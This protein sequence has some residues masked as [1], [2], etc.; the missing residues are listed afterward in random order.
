MA[1]RR[2]REAADKCGN[3]AFGVLTEIYAEAV[4]GHSWA[5]GAGEAATVFAVADERGRP[6]LDRPLR[7]ICAALRDA[8][9]DDLAFI[10]PS[11][12]LFVAAAARRSGRASIRPLT[13]GGHPPQFRK[14]ASEKPQ[15]WIDGHLARYEI[16]LR[17]RYFLD[18][19][20][21]ERIRILAHELWHIDPSFD[22]TLAES[23]RHGR[24]R[25]GSAADRDPADATVDRWVRAWRSAGAVA[26]EVVTYSGELRLAAWT[27]RP[28]SRLGPLGRR[29]YSHRDL[30]SAVVVQR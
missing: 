13:L 14:G 4:D 1:I 5:S 27:D 6:L 2:S 10:D 26:A 8:N 15:I 12:I 18:A 22:G 23:R 19:T 28:P 29:W 17:P 21:D 20:P 30:H 9:S 25:V 3:N 16:N 11:A 24:R 7:N